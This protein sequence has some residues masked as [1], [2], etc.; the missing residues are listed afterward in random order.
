MSLQIADRQNGDGSDLRPLGSAVL[1]LA[2][3]GRDL[4]LHRSTDELS[5]LF[6]FCVQFLFDYLFIVI[7]IIITINIFFVSVT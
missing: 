1:L 6:Y 7:I 3:E 4:H 2:D 5:H